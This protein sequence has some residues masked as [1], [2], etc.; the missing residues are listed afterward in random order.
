MN[1]LTLWIFAETIKGTPSSPLCPVHPDNALTFKFMCMPIMTT[2]RKQNLKKTIF[3]FDK[4]KQRKLENTF[5][6]LK[7]I[8]LGN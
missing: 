2:R 5:K 4:F 6:M 3:D 8:Q 1:H 7:N